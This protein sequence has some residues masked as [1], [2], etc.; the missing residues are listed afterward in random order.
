MAGCTRF[1]GI[2]AAISGGDLRDRFHG[3]EVRAGPQVPLEELMRHTRVPLPIRKGL[4]SGI[5]QICRFEL[6]GR[7]GS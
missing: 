1:P 7:R 5:P 4:R 2:G 6:S 3:W